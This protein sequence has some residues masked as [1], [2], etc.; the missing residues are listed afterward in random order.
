VIAERRKSTVSNRAC[1]GLPIAAISK[2]RVPSVS[3]GCSAADAFSDNRIDAVRQRT[4][5]GC[6][7]TWSA[8][9]NVVPFLS[10]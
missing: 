2:V 4:C 5:Q 3:G 1:P 8:F 7:F 10:Y 9:F 6:S